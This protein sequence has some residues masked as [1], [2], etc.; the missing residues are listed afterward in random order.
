MKMQLAALGFKRLALVLSMAGLAIGYG[1]SYL[2]MPRFVSESSMSLSVAK[3][4]VLPEASLGDMYFRLKTE[5]MS[6]SVLSGIIQDPRLDLYKKDRRVEPLEDVIEAMRRKIRIEPVERPGVSSKD[7]MAF[8]IRFDY[9]DPHKTQA[10][11]QTLL[12]KFQ[13]A[14]FNIQKGPALVAADNDEITRLEVRVA[15]L[16]R[17]L[18]IEDPS[19]RPEYY[20]Q[21][22]H[23]R[24]RSGFN[25]DVLD[26]PGLPELAAFPNRAVF[27]AT[28]FT[29]G[30]AL[31]SLIAVLRREP[32]S[33]VALPV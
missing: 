17:K 24:A 25:L 30:F 26:A 21:L 12:T 29:C 28:G 23:R 32:S 22:A 18:G 10:V 6:R 14:N 5:V 4:G 7:W 27:A 11:V 33:P 2:V 19:N 16:E 20:E 13:E 3:P 8:N 9:G 15:Q 31:A 1:A